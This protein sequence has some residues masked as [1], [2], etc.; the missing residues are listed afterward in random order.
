[1][2]RCTKDKALKIV[3]A[4]RHVLDL[5]GPDGASFAYPARL[6][7]ALKRSLPGVAVTVVAADKAAPV[8]R[9]SG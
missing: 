2:P 5:P 8:R 3:G 4:W 9:G 1:M 6:E 7:A